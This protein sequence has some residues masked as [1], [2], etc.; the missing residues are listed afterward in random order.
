MTFVITQN[1]CTDAS[2]VPVCPAD[3]IRPAPDPTGTSVPMLYIDPTSCVDCG[4]CVAV[5]PVGAIYHEDELPDSQQRFKTINADYFAGVPLDIRASAAPWSPVPIG[6]D[7]LRVAVVGAGPAACYA[8]A[9][10]TRVPGVRVD[11]FDR[12]PTPY[13]LVRFGVAPDHQHTKEIISVF[14]TALSGPSVTCCFNVSVGSDITHD[15]LMSSYDAVIYAVGAAQSRELGIPGEHLSGSVAAAD[16]VNWYNGHPDH[17]GTT[18]R[19]DAERAVI[20]GNGNVALDV[21]RILVLDEHALRMTDVAEHALEELRR[22]TIREVVILGRRGAGEGA[23]SVGELL[24]LGSLSG[25][26]IAVEGRLGPRPDDHEGAMKYDIVSEYAQRTAV[27]GNRRIVLRFGTRPVEVRGTDR[28]EGLTVDEAGERATIDTSIVLRAI[29]YRPVAIPGLPADPQTGVVSNTKGRVTRDGA[30]IPGLYVTGWVKR[31]P[32]G[33]I[34]TNRLCARETVESLLADA[35]AGELPAVAAPP[36]PV[37]AQLSA[38]GVPVVDWSGWTRI[39]RTERDRGAAHSRPRIK[40]VN[41][42]DLL[43]AAGLAG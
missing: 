12:L 35:A 33:V 19:L 9:D 34:G 31:G 24:A 13:G 16:F 43:T 41:R 42:A 36:T 18:F 40:V 5:C 14:E 32:R 28:V 11:V 25:V 21:A 2:C 30:Q 7:A 20:V 4:A 39:D 38:R 8:V 23:F 17:A 10:L 3:C 6:R 15:E 1:C 37:G 29:G 27:A 22:S 26:D